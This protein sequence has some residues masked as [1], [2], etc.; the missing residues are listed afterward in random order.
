M[1]VEKILK[2]LIVKIAGCEYPIEK[3]NSGTNLTLELGY[4]S[5][6]II[7]LIVGIEEKFG[8]VIEDEDLDINRLTGY[9]GLVE[10]LKR[11]IQ[12]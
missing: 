6:K 8:I 7:E 4:D 10:M 11:K 1:N 5:I 3:I 9:S 12:D 2:E